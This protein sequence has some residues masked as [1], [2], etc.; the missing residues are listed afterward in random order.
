V[1]SGKWHKMV[2]ESRFCW[3]PHIDNCTANENDFT[4]RVREE[5][6]ASLIQNQSGFWQGIKAI[7]Y[8]KQIAI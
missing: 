7:P 4:K 3:D 5:L 6:A 1:D 2:F 8:G